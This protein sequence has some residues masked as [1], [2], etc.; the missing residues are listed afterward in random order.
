[1]Q[2]RSSIF[3]KLS[4]QSIDGNSG[5]CGRHDAD[6]YN[7]SFKSWDQL[8]RWSARSWAASQSAGA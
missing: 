6:A 5:K 4:N 3:G 8:V 2:Y 7:K 1:M